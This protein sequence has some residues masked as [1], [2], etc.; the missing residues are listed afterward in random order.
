M[1]SDFYATHCDTTVKNRL[2]MKSVLVISAVRLLGVWLIMRGVSVN[3]DSAGCVS[4]LQ[5]PL[6]D[7]QVCGLSGR[8]LRL[9]DHL[10]SATRAWVTIIE[11]SDGGPGKELI[12]HRNRKWVTEELLPKS[13]SELPKAELDA[14]FRQCRDIKPRYFDAVLVQHEK[15]TEGQAE[16]SWIIDWDLDQSLMDEHIRRTKL[17]LNKPLKS[18]AGF[19]TSVIEVCHWAG[20]NPINTLVHQPFLVADSDSLDDT[21]ADTT[22]E[23]SVPDHS[24]VPV[25]LI[26]S[27]KALL[28]L[29][30]VTIRKQ[31]LNQVVKATDEVLAELNQWSI[32]GDVEL[33][34]LKHDWR[35]GSLYRRGRALG[36][37]ELPDVIAVR[38][39]SDQEW[40][41]KEF[42]ATFQRLKNL[43]D[44]TQPKFILLTIRRERRRGFRGLALNL[45]DQYR[46]TH[47]D[48]VWHFKKRVDLMTELGAEYHAHQAAC[49][50]WQ[51]AVKPDRPVC[52][53]IRVVSEHRPA[54]QLNW[55]TWS[56]QP[57]WRA[58]EL[59]FHEV[60]QRQ[61][62]AVIWLQSPDKELS[63]RILTSERSAGSPLL[64]QFGTVRRFVV[65]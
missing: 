19:N 34:K 28:H 2:K 1:N 52:C 58:A 26:A 17:N 47:P 63:Q 54:A 6:V 37:M 46:K 31:H 59:E 57:P 7:G 36:Y 22:A 49:K 44:V 41:N 3:A 43:V 21:T 14:R 65:Q 60:Q 5:A 29:D 18:V 27:R 42:E 9:P 38:P 40:L 53:V 13:G 15:A 33:E 51:E 45:V 39:V 55:G 24:E 20:D 48:P 8:W 35:A 62:E 4:V 30:D 23:T 61:W 25:S 16:C 32:D 50:M 56:E 64:H 11:R 10:K 12:R